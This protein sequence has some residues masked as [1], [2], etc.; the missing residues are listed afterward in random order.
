MTANQ[1]AYQKLVEDRRHNRVTEGETSRHNIQQEGIG[2]S[3]LGERTRHNVETEGIN[4]YTAE[5]TRSQ[6]EEQARHNAE[7]EIDTDYSNKT[8]R[9]NAW[10]TGIKNVANALFG[11]SGVTGGVMTLLPLLK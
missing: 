4:W 5:T 6:A 11:G 1:I 9:G 7:T 3:D 10:T 2:W 8:N